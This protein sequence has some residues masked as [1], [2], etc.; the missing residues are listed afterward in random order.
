MGGFRTAALSFSER[1]FHRFTSGSGLFFDAASGL[2]R[3]FA[4]FA[5]QTYLSIA[6]YHYGEYDLGP[7]SR[8]PPLACTS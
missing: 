6:W 3:R 5:T 1:A 4:S 8:W 2:R 7:P